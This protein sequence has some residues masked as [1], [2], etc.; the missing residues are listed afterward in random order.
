MAK[1]CIYNDMLND[2]SLKAN[3]VP[4]LAGEVL[5]TGQNCCA[6][7]NTIIDKLP[8]TIPTAQV[9]SSAGCMGQDVAHFDS[10][11]YRKLGKRYAIKMLSL[12][13][14]KVASGE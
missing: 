4:I 12:M 7:M 9:I 1:L 10:E 11:G 5:A 14:I 2:L 6:G 8:E 13:G 3:S